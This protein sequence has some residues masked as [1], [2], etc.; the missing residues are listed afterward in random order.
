MGIRL[1]STYLRSLDLS[2]LGL[3]KAR[4]RTKFLLSLALLIAGAH[5]FATLLW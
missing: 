1:S 4:L 3:A 2:E 5:I